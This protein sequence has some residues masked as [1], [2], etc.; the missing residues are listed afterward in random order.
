MADRP[1]AALPSAV[2]PNGT[3]RYGQAVVHSDAGPE[4]QRPARFTVGDVMSPHLVTVTLATDV[5]LVDALLAE[6]RVSALPVVDTAGRAVGIVSQGD[7]VSKAHARTAAGLMA[8]P[9]VSI[10]PTATLGAAARLMC[11]HGVNHL[12]VMSAGRMLGIL[13]GR[14]L[15]RIFL[16]DDAEIR[17]DIVDGV[18][19]RVMQL[20]TR[21]IRVEVHEG[22][23][24]LHGAVERRSDV[25][26]L[27]ELV[28]SIAG[29]V[30]V[31]V[32]VTHRID[33]RVSDAPGSAGLR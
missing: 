26:I 12:L 3:A 22:V 14:D 13:T 1:G 4:A 17:D 20:E 9:P 27:T 21:D 8:S 7:R 18:I 29:V 19:A 32:H 5:K 33:S 30:D 28:R 24:G 16:R 2:V 10:D 23:V 11:K 31:R 15:L 25:E 6:H